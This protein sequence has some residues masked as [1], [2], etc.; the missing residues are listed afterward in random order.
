MSYTRIPNEIIDN[1]RL[2]PYQFQIFSIIIRKTDGWCKVEDGISLSQFEK[3]V[4][5]SKNTIIKTIKELQELNL[6]EVVVHFDSVKKIHSYN[7]YKVSQGVVHQMNKGSSPDE[8][9]VVHQMNKQKKTITKET[10]SIDYDAFSNL[11]NEFA[12]K[13]NKA[14]IAKLT[15]SRKKKIALRQKEYKNLLEIFTYVLKKSESSDFLLNGNF[16]TFDWL[17][18]NDTNILKVYEGKYDN[19]K[20][21][22]VII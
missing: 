3:L 7:T 8:Q 13:N 16:Y 14:K 10:T 15:D 2:N 1:L 17:I 4:T 12:T 11:W 19:E 20:P 21:K 5:F 22:E 9:G 18:E 6:I